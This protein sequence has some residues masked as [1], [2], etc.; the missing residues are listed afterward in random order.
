MTQL[1]TRP[2]DPGPRPPQSTPPDPHAP[3]LYLPISG[4]QHLLFCARQCALIHVEQLFAE[5]H[6]TIEGKQL[7]TR[8]DLPGLESRQG[9]RVARALWLLSNRLR[10]VGIAD[11][12]EFSEAPG[13]GLRPL[14]VEYKRGKKAPTQ[15]NE[16]QLCAQA[17]ALE[18]MLQVEV[19][20]GAL[21]H[22]Q[23][24]S[25]QAVPFT[26]ALRRLTEETAERYHQ[27]IEGQTVPDAI[28]D[29]RCEGCSLLELCLP[30]HTRRS[31][32]SRPEAFLQRCLRQPDASL[33]TLHLTAW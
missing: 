16:V 24:R 17:M 21:F 2:P 10:L 3:D 8:V 9:L 25:R 1:N 7:H 11:V 15:A 13:G 32:R 6:L 31:M 20:E 29:A 33:E 19:P 14:P 23:T 22:G 26:P 5:N 30:E 28:R 27:L 18:E 4:L 12:V